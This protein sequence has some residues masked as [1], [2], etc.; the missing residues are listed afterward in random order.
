VCMEQRN[1]ALLVYIRRFVIVKFSFA[2]RLMVLFAGVALCSL[3]FSLSQAQSVQ[4]QLGDP[5]PTRRDGAAVVATDDY[6]YYL[7]GNQF[8]LVP[9]GDGFREERVP[10]DGATA[11]YHP[12]T[13]T[14]DTSLPPMPMPLIASDGVHING[15]IYLPGGVGEP[16]TIYNRVQSFNEATGTWTVSQVDAPNGRRNYAAV[17]LNGLIYRIGGGEYIED[18]AVTGGEGRLSHSATVDVYNPATDQW[19]QPFDPADLPWPVMTPCVG[20]MNGKIYVA[21]GAVN[22]S[23][24]VTKTA[25]YDPAT[26]TWDDAGMA[27]LPASDAFLVGADLVLDGQL[28]CVGSLRGQSLGAGPGMSLYVTDNVWAYNPTANSWAASGFLA[29]PR[30]FMEADA[31]GGDGFIIG[32]LATDGQRMLPS[33]TFQVLDIDNGTILNQAANKVYLPIVR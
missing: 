20:T 3:P 8:R 18:A 23:P 24:L 13:N 33:D 5:A 26:N 22:P 32:G 4:W 21:G 10:P 1:S 28:L 31:W 9:D 12:R 7:G 16:M 6:L 27:D 29:A 19:N 17:E 14:W 2:R 11:R 15:T 30:A 25:I